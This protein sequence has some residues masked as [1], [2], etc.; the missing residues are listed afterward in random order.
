MQDTEEN[1]RDI[2]TSQ[3]ATDFSSTTEEVVSFAISEHND[4]RNTNSTAPET[5]YHTPLWAFTRAVR[6]LYEQGADPHDAFFEIE[7]AILRR[8]GWEI[9]ET[10]LEPDD[11]Y[12][13]F[14]CNWARVRY[15]IGE[16][17]LGNALQMAQAHPLMPKRCEEYPD[18]LKRYAEFVSL[19]GWLQVAMGNSSILLPCQKV[20]DALAVSAMS[21]SRYRQIA[22]AD[23]YL[24]MVR[25]HSLAG[26]RATEFR[27]DVSRFPCLR[28]MAQD[29]TD[30]AFRALENG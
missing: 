25:Q 11:I 20:G 13:E 6:S 3:P 12:F 29:G 2:S 9:L 10:E 8:G 26:H 30:T 5:T 17:P 19:A 27:F 28:D 21:V 7:R 15:R 18:L 22:A 16:T 1:Q 4:Y 23:G 14:V 24:A